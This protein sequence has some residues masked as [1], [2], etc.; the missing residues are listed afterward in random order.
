MTFT[1]LLTVEWIRERT[2]CGQFNLIFIGC[3]DSAGL[4]VVRGTKLLWSN[5]K[6]GT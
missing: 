1:S 4:K 3:G 6:T 2:N 5:L